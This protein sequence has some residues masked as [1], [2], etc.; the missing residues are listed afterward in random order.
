M[1]F[2]NTIGIAVLCISAMLAFAACGPK[3]PSCDEDQNCKDHNQFCVDKIC[4]DCAD[5]GHCKAKGPCA[6]CGSDNTCQVPMGGLGDCCVSDANCKDGKCWKLPGADRGSCARC[7]QAADCGAN[8]K[9]VQGACVPEPDCSSE[10]PCIAGQKC[11]G[12]RCVADV[13]QMNPIFFDFDESAIRADARDTLNQ[14]W[15][16]IQKNKV[17]VPISIE[18]HCD[19]RGSDEY[20]MALGTRR[21]EAAKK[22]LGNLGLK[23]NVKTISYG[24]ERPDCRDQSESCWSRNRR[25][26]IKAR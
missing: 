4:R 20:N 1:R 19:E 22:F 25:V 5:A 3:Y 17:V 2:G 18:G 14:D 15:Q 26:D 8:F 13:C 16:C 21:A 12:G 24:E 6:F 9:C 10:K 23:K 7:L 11:D